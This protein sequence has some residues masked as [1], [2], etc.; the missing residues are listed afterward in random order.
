MDISSEVAIAY[1][2]LGA[3]AIA[4]AGWYVA[5]RRK[6]YWEKARARGCP[7]AKKRE[8]DRARR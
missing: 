1:G 6:R 4:F 8:L 5:Y 7:I 2:L 3:S